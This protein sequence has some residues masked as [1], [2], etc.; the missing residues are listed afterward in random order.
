METGRRNWKSA[1]DGFGR[2]IVLALMGVVVLSGA[3][4]IAQSRPNPERCA[5]LEQQLVSDWQHNNSPQ[6]AVSRID[7][8]LVELRRTRR[9]LEIEADKRECYEEFFIFGRSLK[10]NE[11]C[12]ALDRDIEQARR[13]MSR[14]SEERDALSN[15]AQRHLR[16]D[17]LVAELARQG[18]GAT[19]ERE[20]AARRRTN[21][22]FSLWEDDDSGFDRGY[23][24]NQPEQNALPFASYRTM[25]VR[26]CDGYYFP[27]SFSTIGSRFAEDE[28]KCQEQCAAPAQLFVYRNPGED[29]E[30]MVSLDGKPYNDLQNAWRNRKQY[31]KG[32]SCKSYEYSEEQILK[33]EQELA[34]QANA[35]DKT[36][37][38]VDFAVPKSE[39]QGTN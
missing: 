14:L 35:T 29:V 19:Y 3:E 9:K 34:K 22:F 5:A 25:C 1:A 13:D 17:D 38:R 23:Q 20:Y 27:I 21:S 6:E 10:R 28:A 36:S 12:I 18:C 2:A 32:C 4:A 8:Q 30:Q 7:K 15:T 16:R 11:A 33:S 39:D 31:V 24:N 37:S 26:L